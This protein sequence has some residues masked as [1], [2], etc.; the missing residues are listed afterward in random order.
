VQRRFEHAGQ[1]WEIELANTTVAMRWGAL[2]A[3]PK[4]HDRGFESRDAAVAYID[5]Q[6][7][8][9]VAAG[10]VESAPPQPQATA[11]GDRQRRFE[12]FVG[13]EEHYLVVVQSDTT[14]HHRSGRLFGGAERPEGQRTIRFPTIAAANARF[15]E[16]CEATAT[17]IAAVEARA[18]PVVNI[19]A[20]ALPSAPRP[21][22]PEPELV[23]LPPSSGGHPELE[24]ECRAS[25][26]DPAP[27]TV[28]ADW[29]EAQGDP[30]AL[31]AAHLRA[32]Q[33]ER[34]LRVIRQLLH[35]IAD[36]PDDEV[37]DDVR[38]S[39]DHEVMIVYGFRFGF[40]R[41][42]RFAITNDAGIA[43]EIAVKRFLASPVARFVDTLKLGLARFEGDNDWRPVLRA[44]VESPCAQQ[45]RVLAF[46]EFT[47]EDNEL[48]WVEYGDLSG[49]LEGQRAVV[50]R[51]R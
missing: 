25:P 36:D 38:G 32:D 9:Q 4:R 17:S 47:F 40:V 49:L 8:K 34:A 22:I 37:E 30:L 26:D 51:I 24:A 14:V 1:F 21:A 41:E 50:G 3:P 29:L 42:V 15:D 43:L 19:I 10:Y 35:G 11:G 27:W 48:S 6:I 23:A 12:W 16:L 28:Y 46:S 44:I 33:T 31:I 7:A 18:A 2:G 5:Q 20:P 39:A 13:R 45:L